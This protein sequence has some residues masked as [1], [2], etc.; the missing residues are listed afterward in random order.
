[1]RRQRKGW[2]RRSTM[3]GKISLAESRLGRDSA[4]ILP[5]R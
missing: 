4:L 2:E 3:E 1:M 5:D